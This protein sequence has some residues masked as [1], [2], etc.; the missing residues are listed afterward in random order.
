MN[1]KTHLGIL[2]GGQLGSMLIKSAIDFGINVAVMDKN[3]NAPAGKYTSLFTCADPLDYDDVVK[4][5]KQCDIITIE[6]EAVNTE[7]LS[8][9]RDSG[10][11]VFPSP[12][13]IAIVQDK[14]MQ[15]E[16]LLK[17]DI[18]VVP[19]IL[20][21]SKAELQQHSSKLPGCLKLR[22]NGY[23]GKGVMMIHTEKDIEYAFDDP[24]ILEEKVNIKREISVIVSRN[25]SGE[26]ACYDAVAMVFNNEKH[27]LDYQIC[28]ADISEDLK[29]QAYNT[30]VKIAHELEL[31]G[32]LAIEMFVTSDNI[33]LVNE[34]APRPHNSGHHTIEACGSSQYEQHIRAIMNYP[35]GDTRL[36]Y[37]A[38]GMINIIESGKPSDFTKIWSRPNAHL[39]YYGKINSKPGRKI[40]HVTITGHNIESLIE[41]IATVKNILN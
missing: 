13:L 2:G 24:C 21:N 26:V 27:L 31:V 14:H 29:G 22:R 16:F 37:K 1:N 19:S 30:A 10:K 12:E 28:P 8:Y 3:E 38:A 33:L 35:P 23:D 25:V 20:I 41:D 4:F 9:L 11:Q 39:H 5:G 36:R 15:K 32:I 18:A 6:K 40:G 17:H 34:L 7:A